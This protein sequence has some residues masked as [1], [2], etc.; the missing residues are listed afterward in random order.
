MDLHTKLMA[1]F[2]QQG[3]Q[4]QFPSAGIL[5]LLKLGKASKV[6]L[7]PSELPGKS[8]PIPKGWELLSAL[9]P[10]WIIQSG[11]LAQF[12]VRLVLK[13]PLSHSFP[14]SSSVSTPLTSL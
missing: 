2:P 14:V 6:F 11:S 13:F 8:P 3:E 12:S 10:A 4:I 5:E 1:A 9:F 7:N